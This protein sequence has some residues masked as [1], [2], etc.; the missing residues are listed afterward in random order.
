M[1]T[2]RHTSAITSCSLSFKLQFF[3]FLGWNYLNSIKY[4]SSY[5]CPMM[6]LMV[7]L[8]ELLNEWGNSWPTSRHCSLRCSDFTTIN[9]PV[10]DE[11]SIQPPP[12]LYWIATKQKPLYHLFI[13][14]RSILTPPPLP[15]Y[16]L[17]LIFLFSYTI[18]L[19]IFYLID[20]N[21]LHN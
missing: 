19:F 8:D 4:N 20:I 2:E 1:K 13:D 17:S 9:S 10:L 6:L 21:I 14:F 12:P 18:C 3:P 7:E 16:P 11:G 15:Y 5:C